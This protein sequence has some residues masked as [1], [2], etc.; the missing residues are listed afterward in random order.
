MKNFYFFIF[1]SA[2]CTS[3]F[4]Q[5]TADFENLA[6]ANES[7]WNGADGTGSFNSGSIVF[8]NS[9]NQEWGSW[10]GFS[11]SNM[12]DVSTPGF[13][14]QYS[15]IT[16][17]GYGS[18]VNYAIGY[19]F[20]TVKAELEVADS[21]TGLFVTNST[22]AYLTMKDGDAFGFAKKFG[23]EQGI[24][25][26]Y[27][28]L[29][30]HGVDEAGD[31][32]GVVEFY[33]ADFRFDN[34]LMDYI[35]DDWTWVGLSSLGKVKELHFSLESTDVGAWGMNTPAYFCMDDLNGEAPVDPYANKTI[36]TFDDVVLDSTGYLNGSDMKKGFSSGGFD[37]TNIYFAEW[38]YWA[39]FAVSS[40]SDTVTR[41]I[42]NQFSC[43]SGSGVHGSSQ[44]ALGYEGGNMYVNFEPQVIEGFFANNSTFAYWSMMEGDSFAKKFGGEDGNDPDWF[45]LTIEGFDTLDN[46]T[47]KVDFYLADFRFEDNSKDY[48]LKNWKYVDLTSLGE[49]KKLRFRLYSSDV[50]NWGMN[51]P[52]YFC[53]DELNYKDQAPVVANPIADIGHIDN[54][55][56]VFYIPIDSVFT[57]PDDPDSLIVYT[58]ENIDTPDLVTASFVKL[59][60]PGEPLKKHIVINVAE[61]TKGEAIV[62]LGATSNGKTTLHPFKIVVNFFTSIESLASQNVNVYPNPFTNQ[63][64]INGLTPESRLIIYDMEGRVMFDRE[65]GKPSLGINN[66]GGLKPGIY[67]LTIFTEEGKVSKKLIKK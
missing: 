24:D 8:H 15:T 23:G 61:E 30:I 60:K 59:G 41:G 10:S 58:I 19:C 43:I 18:S 31:T 2:L 21:I 50:G 55:D 5:N 13:T 56:R 28:K 39:G 20:G 37:F 40:L 63:L 49:I 66:L 48:I 36:A 46:S 47:G 35:V 52:A 53:M 54:P 45:K 22:Y 6:L 65:A 14:N 4:A 27:F 29:F 12:T 1:L 26:D 3:M 7:F 64:N 17:S 33:L 34:S 62:T 57:D 9:Y 44:Y 67:I 16:G 42:P 38:S 11:Y 51:T 25:P 32:T